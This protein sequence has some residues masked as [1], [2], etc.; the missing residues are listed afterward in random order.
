VRRYDLDPVAGTVSIRRQQGELDAG[1]LIV[2]PPKSA[3]V[4]ERSRYRLPS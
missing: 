1:E 4:S 3:A 2:T